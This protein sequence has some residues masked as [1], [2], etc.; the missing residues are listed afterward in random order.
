MLAVLGPIEGTYYV[1]GQTPAMLAV[2][3]DGRQ[4]TLK[5]N[6][7][8]QQPPGPTNDETEGWS[9]GSHWL[10]VETETLY[11]CAGTAEGEAVW[12]AAGGGGDGDGADIEFG[13][14]G[15]IP[16]TNAE[17][18]GF[19]YTTDLRFVA[20][21]LAVETTLGVVGAG[22]VV[23]GGMAPSQDAAL[24]SDFETLPTWDQAG[25]APSARSLLQVIGQSGA[26]KNFSESAG[27]A[28]SG[29]SVNITSGNG[30]SI[31]SGG[32]YQ[33]VQAGN[34]GNYEFR[35]GL[36]GACLSGGQFGTY[37]GAGGTLAFVAQKGGNAQVAGVPNF[38]GN[39]GS[40]TFAAGNGGI[41]ANGMSNTGGAAGN[42]EF[43]SGFCGTGSTANGALGYVSLANRTAAGTATHVLRVVNNQVG[44]RTTTPADSAA[45]EIG[46]TTGALLL[47]RLTTNQRNNLTAVD[48]MVMYNT[49]DKQ[50]QGR[51]NGAWVSLH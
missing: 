10:D 39:G 25:N 41:T 51:A 37:G 8:A 34:G 27:G 6:W 4:R 43:T 5:A 23:L 40:V 13:L 49:T 30:G 38:G 18:D 24:A 45:L 16:V 11:L 29:A 2:D 12:I 31:E 28:G 48:G 15:E 1:G 42:V 35:S 50:F 36:G 20:G 44:I 26:N 33:F 22:R 19:V 17:A 32:S 14:P 9:V 46:G 3:G 47:P 21:G 7:S